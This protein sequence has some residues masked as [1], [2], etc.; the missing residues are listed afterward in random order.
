MKGDVYLR[1]YVPFL[2][3]ILINY[4]KLEGSFSKRY[5]YFV[6]KIIATP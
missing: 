3:T 4:Y 2:K 1:L 5:S 6:A